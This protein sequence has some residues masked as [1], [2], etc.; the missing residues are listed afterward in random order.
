MHGNQQCTEYLKMSL[1]IL[2][3]KKFLAC[4]FFNLIVM[5]YFHERKTFDL[6]HS[7]KSDKMNVNF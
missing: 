5:N 7:Q 6:F 3:R 2:S 1:N 4:S